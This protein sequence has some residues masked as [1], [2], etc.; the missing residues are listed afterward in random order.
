MEMNIKEDV[1]TLFEKLKN[2][3]QTETVI[4]K[5]II[6][7]E[8]TVVPITTI[9]LCCG[10]PHNDK[11]NKRKTKK[12]DI[13]LGAAARINPNAIAVIKNDEVTMIPIRKKENLDKLIKMIPEIM[14]KVREQNKKDKID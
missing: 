11:L 12:E 3:F 1:D 14:S 6:I 8:V 9:M 5:P 2:F 7:G 4:G 10:T 13:E